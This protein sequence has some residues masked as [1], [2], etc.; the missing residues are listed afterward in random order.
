MLTIPES[1]A[2]IDLKIT[3]VGTTGYIIT[4]V[5]I[6]S[7]PANK[8]ID[9]SDFQLNQPGGFT[10]P[11]RINELTSNDIYIFIA[12]GS[13]GIYVYKKSATENLILK[14]QLDASFYGKTSVDIR[15]V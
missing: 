11:E 7:F 12:A 2:D 10:V 8:D 6:V 4:N 3:I 1:K 15:D 14:K 13:E 5:G 9:S